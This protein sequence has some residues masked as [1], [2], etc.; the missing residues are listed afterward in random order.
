VVF[1]KHQAFIAGC[2]FCY[3]ACAATP[4]GHFFDASSIARRIRFVMTVIWMTTTSV[5]R[6]VQMSTIDLA[7]LESGSNVSGALDFAVATSLVVSW[8]VSTDTPVPADC[9]GDGKADLAVYQPSTVQWF[10]LKSSTNYSTSIAIWWGIN[11]D[12]PVPSDYD[13]DGKADPAVYRSSTGQWLFL[14]SSTHYTSSGS[15]SWGVSTDIPMAADY[16]GDGE[17]DPAVFRPSTGQ[18]FILKSSFNSAFEL[19]TNSTTSVAIAW[20]L[21]TDTPINGR[22]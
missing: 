22:P 21:D 7:R 6:V 18:W 14:N 12:T 1:R 19:G 10:V 3:S 2:P 15:A 5:R 8:G 16:D 4:V 20:G 9:D 13:G 11:T 17:T